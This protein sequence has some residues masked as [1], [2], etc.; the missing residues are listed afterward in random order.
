MTLLEAM[1]IC[2]IEE[3]LRVFF[4]RSDDQSASETYYSRPF[5]AVGMKWILLIAL[6][7]ACIVGT[8]SAY[9]LYLDCPAS[10]QVGLPLKCSI[11]SDLPAGYNLDL[12]MY[13][14]TY[15]ATELSRQSVTIQDDHNT[16]YRLFETEGLPGGMYKIE[17][18]LKTTGGEESLRSDSVTYK[19]VK[20]IDRSSE[21][22]ITSP[23][24][25]AL[26]DALRIEGSVEKLSNE[27]VQIEVRG[28]EGRIFGPQ[29]IGTKTDVKND[30]G[31]FT[32]KI[33][34]TSPGTYEVSFSDPKGFIGIKK[35]TVAEPPTPT[36]TMVVTTVPV[37]TTRPLT[38]IPT[39]LPATTQS[40]LSPVL[41]M[42]A[43][44]VAG[45]LATAAMKR[46]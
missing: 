14:S 8:A 40:P 25:Q 38:T 32:Y 28:P 5:D 27:G 22:T 36:R 31:V 23:E 37:T 1:A 24:T 21:I 15:T 35:F 17:M 26:E 43:L 41:V 7:F 11:D 16:Q 3:L 39:T 2:C 13:Q 4:S 20:V 29:Y 9:G 18:Q 45:L 34:V 10:I 42:G 33:T 6:C 30:A 19:I 46:R 12:V 44:V